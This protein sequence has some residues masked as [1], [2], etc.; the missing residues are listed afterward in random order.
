MSICHWM[1]RFVVIFKQ[2]IVFCA[3]LSGSY[4]SL[5][6]S[7]YVSLQQNLTW[8]L[9]AIE[10]TGWVDEFKIAIYNVENR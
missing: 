1:S 6:E 2:S 10:Y 3:G 9:F 4:F 8:L 7:L 5:I